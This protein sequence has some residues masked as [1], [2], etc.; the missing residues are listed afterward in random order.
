MSNEAKQGT[1]K[2]EN[3]LWKSLRMPS[4]HGLI[5]MDQER[6]ERERKEKLTNMATD[7]ARLCPSVHES[8][9]L[10]QDEGNDKHASMATDD[11]KP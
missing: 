9:K 4:S 7:D 5:E 11:T 2:E 6:R 1:R 10:T 8:R 3:E